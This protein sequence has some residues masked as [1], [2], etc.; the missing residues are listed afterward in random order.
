MCN[1]VIVEHNL[2][3]WIQ[4]VMEAKE[5]S[6]ALVFQ[7]PLTRQTEKRLP[8]AVEEPT[9]YI[10]LGE[11]KHVCVTIKANGTNKYF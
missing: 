2:G 8:E 4:K 1:I 5:L 10:L 9:F 6:Q 11:I 3:F 7:S